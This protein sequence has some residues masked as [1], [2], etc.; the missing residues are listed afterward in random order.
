M[1]Q[2]QPRRPEMVAR[3]TARH[4]KLI[5]AVTRPLWRNDFFMREL[6]NRFTSYQL[7]VPGGEASYHFRA[8]RLALDHW[9]IDAGSLR[10]QENGR[11]LPL[12]I[13]SM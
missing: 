11:D 4:R 7:A 9:E 8:S 5:A 2:R 10:K 13:S 12:L 1:I 3:F 6:G